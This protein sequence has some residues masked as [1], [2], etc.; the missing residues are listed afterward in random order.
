[1]TRQK[2][3]IIHRSPEEVNNLPPR[4]RAVAQNRKLE[5]NGVV[6]QLLRRFD[7]SRVNSTTPKVCNH[8]VAKTRDAPRCHEIWYRVIVY[9]P[10]KWR[11]ST[12]RT[13]HGP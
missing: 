8:I 12:G 9:L 3:L 4:W 5:Y 1:M 10:E 11:V 6:R 7:L 13:I 2:Q